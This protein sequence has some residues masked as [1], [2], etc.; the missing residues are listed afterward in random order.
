LASRAFVL[1]NFVNSDRWVDRFEFGRT[2]G[3]DIDTMLD[4]LEWIDHSASYLVVHG[5]ANIMRDL[6]TNN[7][8]LNYH[9]DTDLHFFD[10]SIWSKP[11]M[12]DTVM[13]PR[14]L[15]DLAK[16]VRVVCPEVLNPG[17]RARLTMEVAISIAQNKQ[18]LFAK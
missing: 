8:D 1:D 6:M 16:F 13:R 2:E 7:Y 14:K 17:N 15:A 3:Y 12:V 9:N 5:Y 4:I 10:T 18:K 11:L